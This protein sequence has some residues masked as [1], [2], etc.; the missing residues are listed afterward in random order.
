MIKFLED[1]IKNGKLEFEKDVQDLQESLKENS[2]YDE[3]S[4]FLFK[5]L[6]CSLYYRD[7]YKKFFMSLN[8]KTSLEY[9][10]EPI[11]DLDYLTIPRSLNML[12]YSISYNIYDDGIFDICKVKFSNGK[13]FYFLDTVDRDDFNEIETILNNLN[14]NSKLYIFKDD[15]PIT[16]EEIYRGYFTSIS[17]FIDFL[18]VFH[19]EIN[20]MEDY[21]DENS[22][23]KIDKI[24]EFTN[25]KEFEEYN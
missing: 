22:C 11:F 4:K 2:D 15:E 21:F 5:M 7:L 24:V 1:V 20:D 6:K 23:N 8:K 3:L 18:N 14:K 25:I 9:Y 17:Q 13:Y 12:L 10:I 19:K 16:V